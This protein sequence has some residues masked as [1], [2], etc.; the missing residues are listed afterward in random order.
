MITNKEKNFISVVVYTYNNENEII[1]F[2][3]NI[4]NTLKNNFEKYEIICVNDA[5]TDKTVKKI[6]EFSKE[7]ASGTISIINMSHY[8]GIELSMNAGVD[9]AIGDFVYEF[10]YIVQ[11]YKEDVILNIYYKSL[12]GYDIVAANSK[13]NKKKTSSMFYNIFNRYSDTEYKISTEEFRILS[14]RAINRIHSISKNIPY[15]KAIYANC[16]LKT[17]YF[18]YETS[19][20]IKNIYNKQVHKNRRETAINSLILFTNI[21][22][23]FS[24]SMSIFMILVVLAVACYTLIIFFKGIPVEGWTTT[25]LFL[26]FTFFGLF[27]IMTIVIKYLEILIDLNFKKTNYLIESIEKIN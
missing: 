19:K 15:R 11:D 14:R 21:G 16:G 26:S 23:K 9:L 10:D 13:K 27:T 2:L 1:K 5:S 17:Y 22:Y 7:I 12:E 6:K 18:E 4:N 20:N 8:Q 25:M 3:K 24:I